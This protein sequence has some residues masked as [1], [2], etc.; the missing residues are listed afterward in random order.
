MPATVRPAT[1]ADAPAITELLNAVDLIE[2]GRPETDLHT[3]EADLKHPEADLERDSWLAFES[4][5]LV[6]YGLLWDESGGERIDVDHYVLPDHQEAGFAVLGLMEARALEKARDNGADRAVVHLHL[7]VRPTTDLARLRDRGWQDVRRY[8]VLR[9]PLDPA[10]DVSP[11]LPDGVRIRPCAGED[12]RRL[13]HRLYQ[14]TFARHFDFQPRAYEAWLADIDADGLDWSLVWIAATDD[15]GDAGFL[16]SRND[17]E[18]MGWIRSIG[19]VPEA[20][21][22]GLGG[23][24]LRQA[25][26]AFAALGRDTVG[27][28]VDTSNATGAPELYRRHGMT[29]HY[30]VDTWE[31]V[32]G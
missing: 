21:G 9:R 22:R 32:L 2:I 6:A 31:T 3:V 15:L 20:R 29:V 10:A 8:H 23:L 5:R 25:F 12:D 19:V 7:N 24:L 30:A 27:L 28:G 4:D 16:M 13:V 17:R 18:A 14:T 26:G 11:A 1:L